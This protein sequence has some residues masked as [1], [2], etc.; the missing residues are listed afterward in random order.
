[1]NSDT[2]FKISTDGPEATINFGK[3]LGALLKGGEVIELAGDLGS[4]KTT[5]MKG[6]LL[7]LG[8]KGDVPSP[9]FTISR[10][11]KVRDGLELHHF[12]FYRIH[13]VDV[14]TSELAELLDDPASIVAVEWSSNVGE[15]ALPKERLKVT[16]EQGM[17]L[18]QRSISVKST[19]DKFRYVI[20]GLAK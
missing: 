1:M 10:V 6:I 16:L 14:V 4:G 17:D 7:G 19:S 2:T 9:T 15:Q 13:G 5:L 18:S 3:I 20:E 8:H 11:Y 12:D